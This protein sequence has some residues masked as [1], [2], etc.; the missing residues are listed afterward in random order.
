MAGH[1]SAGGVP[2]AT[3]QG[4]VIIAT[5]NI[6]ANTK[7]AFQSARNLPVFAAKLDKEVAVITAVCDCVCF[8][9]VNTHW[10]AHII[11][12]LPGGRMPS[13]GDS[14]RIDARSP[15]G[16]TRCCRPDASGDG[17]LR[18]GG[19]SSIN[20]LSRSRGDGATHRREQSATQDG[21]QSLP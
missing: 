5:Y 16:L 18:V 4:G 7:D 20:A 17:L 6:G 9:E 21:S 19:V 2:L 8:Q 10:A 15:D 11:K 12:L 3:S 14:A 13:G 1:S